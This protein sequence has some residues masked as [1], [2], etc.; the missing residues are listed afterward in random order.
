MK[1]E[2]IGT[3]GRCI[4]CRSSDEELTDEHVVPLGLG[5]CHVLNKASC[6][7]CQNITSKIERSILRNTWIAPRVKLGLPTRRPKNRPDVIPLTVERNGSPVIIDI[8]IKKRP[9]AMVF[10]IYEKPACLDKTA[11]V[12]GTKWKG[13]M[14]VILGG[15]NSLKALKEESQIKSIT[16]SVTFESNNFAWLIAKIAYGFAVAS[17]G[18]DII[19]TAYVREAILYRSD[20][21]GYWVGC[22]EKSSSFNKE[23][24][25]QVGF[26]ISEGDI[27]AYVRLFV[28]QSIPEYLVIVGPKPN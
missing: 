7:R 16:E 21:I 19:D 8:P 13:L 22:P 1:K 28:H 14:W 11:S 10:P 5:G 3:V 4:Y 24:R 25:Y 17:Y 12:T 9:T 2:V 15:I 23:D 26:S 18:P 27:H 20:T 6:S